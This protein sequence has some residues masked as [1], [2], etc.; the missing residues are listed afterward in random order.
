MARVKKS[1]P[2]DIWKRGCSNKGVVMAT[3]V[4]TFGVD[5]RTRTKQLGAEEKTRRKKC[6]VTFSPIRKNR[7]FQKNYLR[8]GVRNLPRTGF[9]PA[10]V[11]R[12]QAVGIAPTE[13]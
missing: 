12:G 1:I 10:R 11:W 2:A 4:E 9:V 8:T 7:V 13:S 3:S 6:E 5:L